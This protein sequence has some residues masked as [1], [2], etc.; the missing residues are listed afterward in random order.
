MLKMPGAGVVSPSY[1]QR[2][3]VRVTRIVSLPPHPV[4]RTAVERSS[5][6]VVSSA[7]FTCG[8]M[9]GQASLCQSTRRAAA[10]GVHTGGRVRRL[11]DLHLE[12]PPAIRPCRRSA[13]GL[14]VAE[15]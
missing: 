10:A 15:D 13:D 3:S 11:P 12:S 2:S 6:V 14:L 4:A 7:D 1:V 5:P 9:S 8:N